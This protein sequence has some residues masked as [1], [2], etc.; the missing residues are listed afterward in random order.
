VTTPISQETTRKAILSS[1]KE[2]ASQRFKLAETT[3]SPPTR[4]EQFRDQNHTQF[5]DLS[6]D[7]HREVATQTAGHKT[8]QPLSLKKQQ[9]NQL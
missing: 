8:P 7:L 9:N 5:P 3:L 6:P 2:A 1:S 4:E